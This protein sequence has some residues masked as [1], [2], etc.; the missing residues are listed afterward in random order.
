MGYGKNCLDLFPILPLRTYGYINRCTSRNGCFSCADDYN[1]CWCV[2]N[3]SFVDIHNLCKISLCAVLVSVVHG[4]LA[5]NILCRVLSL[6]DDLQKAN[7]GIK[8]P[9]FG[10]VFLYL[11][12]FPHSS[13][14][15]SLG[16]SLSEN[17]TVSVWDA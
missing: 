5:I 11:V 16:D 17:S 14:I 15:G 4:H 9:T 3:E 10:R 7:K 8:N 13:K 1:C 2:R 12:I 6:L